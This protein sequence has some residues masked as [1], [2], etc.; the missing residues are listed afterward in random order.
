MHLSKKL[1]TH[2][3][4]VV[5]GAMQNE[6]S[7]SDDAVAAFFLDTGQAGQEL[8]GHVFAQPDLAELATGNLQYLRFAVGRLAVHFKTADTKARNGYIMNFAKVVLQPF[9]RHP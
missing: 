5:M 9:H 4:R 3:T 8:V 2:G 7:R 6:S 1:Q